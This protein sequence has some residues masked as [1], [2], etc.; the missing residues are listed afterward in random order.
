MPVR[1]ADSMKQMND[2]TSF[3]VA[4]GEGIW[5]NK[6]K[7][8]ATEN[9]S[10]LQTM[11]NNDE[12]GNGGSSIQVDTMP[13]ASAENENM[14][15]EYVGA[16]GTY[17]N[18]YF[19]Q[20]IG[21]GDPKVY[22]WVQKNVQPSN[23]T[24]TDVSYDNTTSELTATNVQDAIDEIKVGLG[25]ASG[26]DYTDTVRPN[27]HDLVESGSV[28]SAINNALNTI[29][30][31]R[32]SLTCAELTSSL[33][34]ADNVG[35]VYEMSDSGVTSALFINGAGLTINVGDNV[36][37]I[38]AGADTYLFNYMGN[39][40]DLT[41]YQKKELATSVLGEDT[42]EGALGVIAEKDK[43][44]FTDTTAEWGL[45]STAEKTEYDFTAFSD[46]DEADV[47]TVVD[48][49]TDGDM[50]AV[51]SNAVANYV[52]HVTKNGR[53]GFPG[54]TPSKWEIIEFDDNFALC[55]GENTSEVMFSSGDAVYMTLPDGYTFINVI[56]ANAFAAG[57]TAWVTATSHR[58]S[59]GSAI[60]IG[61][62]TYLQAGTYSPGNIRE[63]LIATKN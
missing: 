12:L 8:G 54:T 30:T 43:R 35:N 61:V 27:S 57:N 42:V 9:Y 5:L 33:L 1:I 52:K 23:A 45:L 18:G 46:E 62:T 50:H 17:Q 26:K 40:F 29:Y 58:Y 24:A 25:T 21:S 11:Y 31:P 39:A 44:I 59:A 10:D 51:T 3:P 16:S 4:Y 28:Y 60:N 47:D 7:T 2:L 13:I 32:G 6:D 14:I 41:D 53:T 34:I 56:S 22:S 37:I 55:I 15:V 38:K 36:G 48:A 20:N 63:I 19:Y 49:V